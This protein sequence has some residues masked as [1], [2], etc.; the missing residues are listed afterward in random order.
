MGFSEKYTQEKIGLKATSKVWFYKL[1]VK[2]I[3]RAEYVHL[4]SVISCSHLDW[5]QRLKTFSDF[6]EFIR[7]LM[8]VIIFIFSY[9]KYLISRNQ[10]K[11]VLKWSNHLNYFRHF[12]RQIIQL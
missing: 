4:K 12:L 6:S 7:I 9:A 8:Y 2:L 1:N 3:L 5:W 11:E 10:I